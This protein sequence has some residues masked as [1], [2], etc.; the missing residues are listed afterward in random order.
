LTTFIGG[1]RNAELFEKTDAQLF[2]IAQEELGNIL[3]IM[4]EPIFRKIKRW[5]KAIPQYNIG[6]EK[7]ENS[8]ED[9]TKKNRG[10]FFCSNF[11][12]GISVG[13]C[14]KNARQ[15]ADEIEIF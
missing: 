6:Y 7:T 8:I 11:Y 15:I 12:G 5:Q 10:I 9:F 1:A 13:D 14:V 4:G 3:G 2:G